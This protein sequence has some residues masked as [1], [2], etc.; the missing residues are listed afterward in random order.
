MCVINYSKVHILNPRIKVEQLSSIFSD[1]MA[2]GSLTDYH[3]AL[4]VNM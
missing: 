1:A 2:L 3:L 4:T